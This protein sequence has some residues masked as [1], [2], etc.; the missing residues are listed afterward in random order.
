MTETTI[1]EYISQDRE[2]V[3]KCRFELQED[4]YIREPHYW[5]KPQ[6]SVSSYIDYVLET[7]NKSDGKIF[8]AEDSKAVVG[9]VVVIISG[10]KDSPTVSLER[11]GYIMDLA[12]LRKYQGKGLG[13]A[14]MSKAEEH[15]KA[16]G[17]EWMQLDVT[18]N[19]P[20]L[21]FYVK[22]GYS[23]KSIRLEKKLN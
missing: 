21:D 15:I 5:K 8:V 11:F 22:S 3:E 2:T 16:K 14:L 4:E 23:E 20:A 7:V 1:R 17:L 10:K 12:V 18:K 13:H 9:F 6:E 19:N